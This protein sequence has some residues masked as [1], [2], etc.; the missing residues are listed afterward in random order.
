MTDAP[1]KL[2]TGQSA[3]ITGAGRGIGRAIAL[4]FAAQGCNVAVCSRTQT[5]IVETARLCE[6]YGVDVIPMGVDITDWDAVSKML[7]VARERFIRIDILVN[8]AGYADFDPFLEQKPDTWSRTLEVNLTGTWQVSKAVAKHMVKHGGGRII[9][10]ASVAGHKPIVNQSAYCASKH[11]LLGLS[12]CMALELREHNIAV[13]AISPGAV[14][15]KLAE[16]AM[17]ERADRDA[18]MEPEDV[19][20]AALYLASL[21]PRAA[22]DDLVLRRFASSPLG[23]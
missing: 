23:G 14:E 3:I 4:A 10:I 12:K 7:L 19:A 16:K 8:N 13:N 2:L 15:T 21:S 11:G 1:E 20:H 18:W 5:E 6:A 22:V 17:G 9:N